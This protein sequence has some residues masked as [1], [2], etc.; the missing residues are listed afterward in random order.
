MIS[1]LIAIIYVAFISLGLPDSLLG[2]GWP[3]IH[4][5]L[6]VG[7]SLAGIITCIITLGTVVSSLASDALTRKLGAGLV[8]AVSVL[9]TAVSLWGFG[10]SKSF[11]VMCLWAVPYGLGA[12]AVDAA[13]NNYVALHYSA[14]HMSW[15][16]CFWGVGAS[17]SPYIMAECLAA[18]NW[19][20]GYTTV[21]LI[22]IILSAVIFA[23]LPLWKK[24]SSNSEEI[25]NSVP[26]SLF[27]ALKI[28]GVPY[29]LTAFFAYCGVETTTGLW[30]STYL[31]THRGVDVE[32]AARFA[33]LFYL[34][35]T[36]GRFV[37]GFFTQLF[38]DKALIRIGLAV[39]SVGIILVVL[40]L[41]TTAVSLAGLI[42]IELGGAP[43]YPSIIHSTPDN[44]GRENS[45]AIIGIQMASAY[46]GST[47]LPPVFGFI[48][49]HVSSALYPV[50]L[51][52]FIIITIIMTERLNWIK[53]NKT[54]NNSN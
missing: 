49:E 51:A 16:H 46:T 41:K 17:I 50:Y 47:L 35:I 39:L 31:V 48:A 9:M 15:L 30:A 33:S 2:A 19:R 53:I 38:S 36:F 5:E 20:H 40:P 8:T 52:I 10:I 28:R 14:R 11:A 13:L 6:G 24:A 3:A 45:Q 12:G 7:L 26:L 34:G 32:T 4:V 18:S 25:E 1:L 37:C 23:S 27:K 44:F 22:Q 29:M 42:I 54:E 21:S 43:I